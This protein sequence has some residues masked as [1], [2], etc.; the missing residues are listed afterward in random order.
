MPS[1]SE[2]SAPTSR[3]RPDPFTWVLLTTVVAVGVVSVLNLKHGIDWGDDFALYLRQARAVL[4]GDTHAVL[5]Q[6]EFTISHSSWGRFTPSLYPWGWPLL[7]SP[8][9]AVFGID[10]SVFKLVEV[11]ALCVLLFCYGRWLLPRVGRAAAWVLTLIVGLS[12]LYVAS[13]D[14]VLSD[15]PYAAIVMAALVML[16]RCRTRGAFLGTS[17]RGLI[18]LGLLVAAAFAFRRE[19]LALVVAVAVAQLAE[20]I[21]HRQ[22]P[23]RWSRSVAARLAT[24]YAAAGAVTLAIQ[25]GLGGPLLY[26]YGGTGWPAIRFNF[27]NYAG[28]AAAIFGLGTLGSPL[29]PTGRHLLEALLVLALIGAT[30]RVLNAWPDD[31]PLLAYVLLA[32]AAILAQPFSDTRYLFTLAPFLLYF[33]YQ[34]APTLVRTATSRPSVRRAAALVSVAAAA[35]LASLNATHLARMTADNVAHPGTLWGPQTPDEAAMFAAVRRLTRPTDVV[36]FWRARLMTFETGRP[37]IQVMDLGRVQRWANCY[38][39]FDNPGFGPYLDDAQAASAGLTR[40]WQDGSY[41]L[42]RVSRPASGG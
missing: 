6:N 12:P 22:P 35:A 7:L 25:L 32:G 41:V 23:W 39:M 28:S 27:P 17:T 21:R 36:A 31:V 30:A 34:A 18:G 19:G 37:A 4:H 24:P 42:W 5:R 11:A 40:V 1:V 20:V 2:S 33:A 8:F 3:H 38:V 13:T 16:D 15:L 9:V 10:Y 14:T 26:R 29:S